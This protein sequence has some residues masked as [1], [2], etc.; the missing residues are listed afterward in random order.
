[1]KATDKLMK[2]RTILIAWLLLAALGSLM[3][4][5]GDTAEG[6]ADTNDNQT[7]AVTTE[8]AADDLTI[9]DDL[10]DDLDFGGAVSN[11]LYRAEI[12]DEFYAEKTNGDV[13]NDALYDSI[14]A[15]EDRLN[16]DIAVHEMDGHMA[17]A[18][19]GYMTHIDN[20]ILAGDDLYDWVDLMIGQTTIR[21]QSGLFMNLLENPYIDIEK[22]WY[23]SQMDEM[24]IADNLLFVSGDASLGYLKDAFVI[25]FNKTT[26]DKYQLG[27]MYSMVHDGTW[28]LDKLRE[29]TVAASED[30]NGD[31]RYDKDDRI[32]FLVHNYN[33]LTGFLGS[34]G[35]SMY[36]KDGDSYE[37][38]F[39]NDRD[40]NVCNLLYQTLY[41]TPGSY[42]CNL[43]DTTESE[44]ADYV[45]LTNKFMTGDILMMTAQLH[46]AV[47]Y[48][49]DME[50]SYGV[51]PYPKY[52]EEQSSYV[53]L[54]R[55]TQNAFSMPKT[56]SDT[57]RAGAVLE[58]LSSE[59]YNSVVPAYYE[60][61]MKTKYS[62]DNAS[63]EM[64]DL[65]R[66]SVTLNF[67]FVYGQ[68]IGNPA[69]DVF[70]QC[71]SK[72]NVVASKVAANKNKL[73]SMIEK[74]I[75]TIEDMYN[76]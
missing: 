31:G 63:A 62:R 37:F 40:V 21:L 13:V 41:N 1:M 57:A 58:A 68:A 67:E 64:F 11:F 30:L 50:D 38:T 48:L 7:S 22:P 49:R 28:T 52:D 75:Q 18:R 70:R 15:V 39:G 34:T 36:T 72:E 76:S 46:E 20:S 29:I 47:L 26:A 10:P 53:T 32:G 8:T 60:I 33:H 51:L 65:I 55:S 3:S 9:K 25:Y 42:D 73:D 61:A 19:S 12:A 5:C 16:V 43:S 2:H 74:Y 71:F 35:I 6:T 24:V 54:S 17:S 66:A 56:C 44:V 27:D 4:A 14:G 45:A 23:L 69:L 59:K